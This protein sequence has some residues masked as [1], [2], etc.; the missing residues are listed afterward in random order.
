MATMG[1]EDAAGDGCVL[2]FGVGAGQG[3]AGGRV[4]GLATDLHG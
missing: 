4:T 3:G 1:I 2:R